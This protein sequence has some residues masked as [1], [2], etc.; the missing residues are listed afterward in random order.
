MCISLAGWGSSSTRR[1]RRCRSCQATLELWSSV[2]AQV[3][4]E[5]MTLAMRP[6]LERPAVLN[7][8]EVFLV[9]PAKGGAGAWGRAVSDTSLR[10]ANHELCKAQ[11]RELAR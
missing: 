10:S 5:T 11:C 7:C 9:P 3:H 8:S 2:A 6:V 1:G 4:S